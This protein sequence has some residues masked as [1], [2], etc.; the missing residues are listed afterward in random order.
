MQHLTR[1]LFLGDSLAALMLAGAAIPQ[2]SEAAVM[3]LPIG[4]QLFS[5]DPELKADFEGTLHKVRQIGYTDVE[6]VGYY[7]RAAIEL[8]AALQRAGL[9][10]ESIHLRPNQSHPGL[11]SLADD[12]D[13]HLSICRD[14]G[15][16]YVV[17]PGPWLPERVAKQIPADK[18]S[19]QAFVAAAASMTDADWN[20]SAALVNSCAARARRVGLQV[21]Y[22]NGNLEFVSSGGATGFDRLLHLMDPNLVKLEFDC[23]WAAVAGQDPV[24][25]LEA[26]RGRVVFAHIKDMTATAVN[27]SMKI[28]PSELGAGVVDWTSLIGALQRCG[29]RRAFV[30]QESPLVRPALESAAANYRFLQSLEI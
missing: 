6:I 3:T 17:L 30:E 11:G 29:V 20:A 21:L 15:L 25:I 7:G 13:K 10:C 28:N 22:H 24:K 9:R 1:R 23:G 12:P 26:Q 14:L 16:Q 27:T 4:L 2:R 8:K 19:L 18:L 5:L